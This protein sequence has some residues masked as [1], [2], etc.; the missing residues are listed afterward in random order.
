MWTT[1]IHA[2]TCNPFENVIKHVRRTRLPYVG[3]SCCTFVF[4][5]FCLRPK[6]PGSECVSRRLF[7]SVGPW[8]ESTPRHISLSIMST[9]GSTRSIALRETQ[10]VQVSSAAMVASPSHPSLAHPHIRFREE[11]ADTIT[12][13]QSG[14][15]TQAKDR[16]LGGTSTLSCYVHTRVIYYLDAQRPK[17]KHRE[18]CRNHNRKNV[19]PS[20]QCDTRKVRQPLLAVYYT[21]LQIKSTQPALVPPES[22]LP[23]L[24]AVFPHAKPKT[25]A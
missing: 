14:S 20:R 9:G 3:V 24:P 6:Y 23:L 10:L 4:C 15:N 12:T 8:S 1:Q 22:T 5:I 25:W 17:A 19:F 11:N 16:R 7:L 21:S 2:T 18:L 13:P